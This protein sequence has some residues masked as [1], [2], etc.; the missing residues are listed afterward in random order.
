VVFWNASRR[1]SSEN[2][3]STRAA[4]RLLAWQR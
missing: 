3:G 4:N 2:G 1:L